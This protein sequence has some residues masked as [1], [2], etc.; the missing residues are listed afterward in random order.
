MRHGEVEEEQLKKKEQCLAEM[1]RWYGHRTKEE[2]KLTKAEEERFCDTF[3]EH[4]EEERKLARVRRRL[5]TSGPVLL[6]SRLF[7]EIPER[8]AARRS[9]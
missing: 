2:L 1:K 9:K 6:Q 8:R 5:C 3:E 4:S 7:A